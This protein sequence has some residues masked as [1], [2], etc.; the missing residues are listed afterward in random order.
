MPP[1]PAPDTCWLYLIRH[2]ATANNNARPPRLQGQ[3]IDAELCDEGREQA[4]RTAVLLA[5][6][7]LA[8]VYASPLLRARQTAEIIAA[9]HGLSVQFVHEI[10]EGD[11]GAW[12]GLAW[13]EVE[14]SAPEDARLF[15]EDAG[16][17]PFLGGE[18]LAM[19][20]MRSVPAIERLMRASL[21]RRIAVI[22]HNLVNRC[23]VAHLLQS[24]LAN[25]RAIAQDNCGVN[26]L[27]Y[28][29][30]RVRLVT[31]NYVAHLNGERL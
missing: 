3:G 24:P 22:A 21:G 11:V 28:R 8:A 25:Y 6:V 1:C 16:T 30:D 26:T 18:N 10:I 5:D 12:E 13:D 19:I 14:R 31:M 15:L 23:Y 4:R 2:G 27:C 20:Q 17:N 9:P 29:A 7:G